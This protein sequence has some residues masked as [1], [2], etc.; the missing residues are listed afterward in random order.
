MK[1]MNVHVAIL[2]ALLLTGPVSAASAACTNARCTDAAAIAQVR[3]MVQATCDCTGSGQT[4]GKYVRCVKTALKGADIVA[5]LPDRPCRRLVT[6][7]EAASICGK[8]DAAVCCVKK[9]SGK[10]KASVAKSCK[11]GSACGALLGFFSTSDACATDGTCAGPAVTTTTISGSTTTTTIASGGGSVLKGALAATAGRFNY[12]LAL[13]LP[14]ANSA[15]GTN[16]PG[17]HVCTY[18]ELQ[19]AETAGDLVGLQD[20]AHSP[21]TSFWAIDSNQPALQQCNDDA[22]GGSGLNWEYATAHTMSRGQRVMLNNAT[23]ALGALQSSVQC[24]IAGTSSV[25]CCQ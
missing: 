23:G 20:V 7:C 12:N 3:A 5:L 1:G 2:A 13:G 4:H 16:F 8:P 22:V 9:P 18:A 24:N 10:V 19:S 21:V 14:G 17:T 11:K 25:G 6:S 15:C